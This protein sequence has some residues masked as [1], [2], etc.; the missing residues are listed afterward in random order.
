MADQG[1]HRQRGSRQWSP[2]CVPRA[3]THAGPCSRLTPWTTYVRKGMGCTS[4]R[5]GSFSRTVSACRFLRSP[6][7]SSTMACDSAALTD[8]AWMDMSLSVQG[9]EA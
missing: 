7:A 6:R 8:T 4:F 1:Q 9:T 2:A 5:S 3:P